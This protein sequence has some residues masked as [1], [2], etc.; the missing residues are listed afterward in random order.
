[1]SEHN[2]SGSSAGTPEMIVVTEAKFTELLL[3]CLGRFTADEKRESRETLLRQC[4][5]RER[6]EARRRPV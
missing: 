3:E 5:E 6:K 2:A 1:M 4:E